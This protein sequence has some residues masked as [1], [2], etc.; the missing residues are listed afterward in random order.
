LY[1]R[2]KSGFVNKNYPNSIKTP[3][4]IEY[5]FGKEWDAIQREKAIKA[6]EPFLKERLIESKY[7][8]LVG[9]KPLKH[10]IIKKNGQNKGEMV[11]NI[12]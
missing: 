7:N 3:V 9:Y 2:N 10:I 8:K 11:L 6:M 12:I 1:K 4:Y 5:L